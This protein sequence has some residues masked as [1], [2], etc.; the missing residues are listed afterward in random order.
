MPDPTSDAA[1]VTRL[2][3]LSR[4]QRVSGYP[5]YID[6]PDGL[7]RFRLG[8]LE[9]RNRH[10]M[11]PV[12]FN[13][14][15]R[16][17]DTIERLRLAANAVH[18][19]RDHRETVNPK[20]EYNA[21][22]IWWRTIMPEGDIPSSASHLF[23]T[24]MASARHRLAAE[25]QHRERAEKDEEEAHA[26]GVDE[27]YSKAVQDLDLWTGGDGEYR[28]VMGRPDENHCPDPAAMAERIVQ[29][30][31]DAKAALLASEQRNR[32]LVEALQAE[33]DYWAASRELAAAFARIRPERKAVFD[34]ATRRRE[35]A[36]AAIHALLPAAEGERGQG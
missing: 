3:R 29:R 11:A 5:D 12:N 27:G 19:A 18:V 28:F 20:S 23:S 10:D 34:A 25:A 21:F 9:A 2:P 14:L 16:L 6:D 13:S 4:D 31:V 8:V 22:L 36:R 33:D 7:E 26:I 17:L 35:Q 32:A 30:V 24:W 1:P 15:A